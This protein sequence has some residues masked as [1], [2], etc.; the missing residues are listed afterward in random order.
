MKKQDFISIDRT[1]ELDEEIR[2][3]IKQHQVLKLDRGENELFRQ[4]WRLKEKKE[5]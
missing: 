5:D 3:I 4:N 2:N 1:K